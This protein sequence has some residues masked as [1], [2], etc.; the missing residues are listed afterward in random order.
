MLEVPLHNTDEGY[1]YTENSLEGSE[2][3]NDGIFSSWH[4][5]SHNITFENNGVLED[6]YNSLPNIQNNQIV[7]RPLAGPLVN[8]VTYF[9]ALDKASSSNTTISFAWK[10]QLA[11]GNTAALYFSWTN[12]IF[13]N[14]YGASAP[15]LWMD[16][17]I[18][19]SGLKMRLRAN[20]LNYTPLVHN[21]QNILFDNT[22]H[23]KAPE[24]NIYPNPV[25]QS[26]YIDASQ[27][28]EEV[29]TLKL[30]DFTGRVLWSQSVDELESIELPESVKDGM[31]LAVIFDGE[32]MVYRKKILVS[33]GNL[34]AGMH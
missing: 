6:V 21:E 33:R 31:Y 15:T 5:G 29:F 12:S 22:E 27:G 8:G 13:P 14:S 9:N 10:D 11:N 20:V 1:I 4:N 24:F 17:T 32:K 18:Q 3:I 26:L 7:V 19:S 30:Y 2:I 25:V 16:A 23:T 34:S 28:P